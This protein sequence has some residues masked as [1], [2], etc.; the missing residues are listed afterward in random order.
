MVFGFK[1]AFSR[2]G[3]PSDDQAKQVKRVME[4]IQAA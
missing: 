4:D 3:L 1:V 2:M